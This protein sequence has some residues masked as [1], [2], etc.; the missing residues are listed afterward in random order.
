MICC[1]CG[2]SNLDFKDYLL[3]ICKHSFNEKE[4]NL[5]CTNEVELNIL[6]EM[7]GQLFRIYKKENE[8]LPKN[9]VFYRQTRN[10]PTNMINFHKKEVTTIKQAHKEVD[11]DYIKPGNS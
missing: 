2:A 10:I 4:P 9:V 8:F 5:E 6:K 7:S 3:F 11:R 1:F